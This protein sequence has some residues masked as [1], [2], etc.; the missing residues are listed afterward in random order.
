MDGPR[1][2]RFRGH[3]ASSI[4]SG[5]GA[6]IGP[7]CGVLGVFA[8]AET[9]VLR[10]AGVASGNGMRRT[11]MGVTKARRRLIQIVG[12]LDLL[13]HELRELA[14]GLPRSP[15]RDRMIE[16]EIPY[17]VATQLEASLRLTVEHHLRPAADHLREASVITEETLQRDFERRSSWPAAAECPT[18]TGHAAEPPRPPSGSG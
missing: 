16:D 7:G 5:S 9:V 18:K 6:S 17:D 3:E 8:G 13:A 4:L 1:S 2:R 12:R 10:D 14:A 15:E 11:K